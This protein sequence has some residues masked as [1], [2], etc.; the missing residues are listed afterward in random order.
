M[1][2]INVSSRAKSLNELLKK[3]RRSGMIL[4]SSD[5]RRFILTSIESWEGF[6]VGHGND[7]S[8][9]VKRTGQNKELLEF[10]DKRRR[11]S[12]KIPLAKVKEQLGLN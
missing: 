6:E 1:K 7:F 2:T 12:K 9:E 8:Q 5:G 3:A 4:Q 11:S 10:L